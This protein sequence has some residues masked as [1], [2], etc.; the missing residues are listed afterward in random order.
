MAS[1]FVGPYSCCV[2]YM[3]TRIATMHLREAHDAHLHRGLCIGGIF[4]ASQ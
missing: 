3:G 2:G 4:S 1:R